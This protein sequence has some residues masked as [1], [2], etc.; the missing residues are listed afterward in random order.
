MLTGSLGVGVLEG[1]DGSEDFG[2]GNEDIGTALRPDVDLSGRARLHLAIGTHPVQRRVPATLGAFIDV[3]L[4]DSGPDHGSAAGVETTCDS[5]D[6]REA[7]IE[8]SKG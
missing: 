6:R 2:Q 4:D 8:L 1:G 5:L 3:V 7:N